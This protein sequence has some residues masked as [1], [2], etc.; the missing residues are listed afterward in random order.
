MS[1]ASLTIRPC[2]PAEL[3]EILAVVND[4]AIAYR[5]AIA[6]DR[7]HEPYMSAAELLAEIAGGV[8]FWGALD[9]D[10]LVGVMGLQ[11]AGD[12]ALVRHAY[13][14]TAR[15]GE[16][17]G[18]RLLAHVRAESDRPMLVGTW[19]AATW[20]IRFYERHDFRLVDG[21]ERVALLRRYW[22]IPARQVEESVVLADARWLERSRDAAAP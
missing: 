13:T 10:T 18:A 2:E 15:Q 4:A 21:A 16:G 17:I 8:A 9:R 1:T 22:S 11:P 5:G 7:W 12:V 19:A 20:A 3:E 6:A 14:R